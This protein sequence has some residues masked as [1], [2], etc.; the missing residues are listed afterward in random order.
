MAQTGG[1]KKG[2]GASED[3]EVRLK[4]LEEIVNDLDK[5]EIP[6]QDT[7]KLF[8]EGRSLTKQLSQELEEAE[9]KIEQLVKEADG[10]LGTEPFEGDGGEEDKE[11]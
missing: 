3:F 9:K 8:E 11:S 10:S 6:L 7:I 2:K 4:R 5:G 1:K